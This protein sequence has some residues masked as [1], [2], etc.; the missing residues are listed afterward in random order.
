MNYI[1]YKW[2]STWMYFCNIVHPVDVNQK[3]KQYR[4][5]LLHSSDCRCSIVIPQ[6][7][8]AVFSMS[9]YIQNDQRLKINARKGVNVVDT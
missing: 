2:K 6:S 8:K 7:D 4:I 1:F 5:S 9:Y 3:R